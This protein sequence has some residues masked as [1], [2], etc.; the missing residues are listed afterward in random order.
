MAERGQS[1]LQSP[2]YTWSP[3]PLE[4]PV[5]AF[6]VG[7]SRTRTYPSLA[8]TQTPFATHD[9]GLASLIAGKTRDSE[10]SEIRLAGDLLFVCCFDQFLSPVSPRRALVQ[11]GIQAPAP[12]RASSPPSS[13]LSSASTID[14]GELSSPI[15][16]P[17]PAPHLSERALGYLRTPPRSNR[18]TEEDQYVTTSWG[19]P[20]PEA[21][22]HHL[23]R[24]S[25]SSGTSDESPL[26]QL[27]IDT[28]FLRPVPSISDT[29][30]TALPP[31]P[32][33]SGSAAVLAN[34]ARRPLGG[35]TEEWIRQHTTNDPSSEQRHWLSDGT[36]DSEHSSLSSS[37]S[38]NEAG[39]FEEADPRTP[40]PTLHSTPVPGPA[41]RQPRNRS[42]NETLRQEV[43]NHRAANT[44]GNMDPLD[45]EQ[46]ATQDAA[47]IHTIES[48]SDSTPRP[49]TP[50][51][52]EQAG[53]NGSAHDMGIESALPITPA[54]PTKQVMSQT[55]RLKKK[56]PWRGK[57][58]LVLIP[59]DE[60]RGQPGKAPKPLDAANTESMLRSWE[61]LGYNV[62]GFDL[63]AHQSK[64][65]PENNSRSRDEWPLLDDVAK[66]RSLRQYHVTL[67]DL[68]AWGKYV[69]ELAEAKLRALGVTFAEEEPVPQPS[70]SPVASNM[71]RQASNQFSPFPF[72]P[73]LPTSS[74]ASN[75]LQG[76]PF[77]APFF[78][79]GQTASQ[80]PALPAGASPVAFNAPI[81]GRFNAR[82]SISISPH[83]LPFH[84][85][86]Q[87]SPLGWSPQMLLQQQQLGRSASPSVLNP[88]SPGSP[89]SPDGMSPSMGIHQR[90]QSL[91]YPMLPHQF[92]H[93]QESARASP[94]LQE[95]REDDEE[96]TQT[97]PYDKSPSKTPEPAQF[98][99]HNA[100]NSLQ[101]EIDEAEYH[102]EEQFRSQLEHEDY[103]PHNEVRP[104]EADIP[105]KDFTADE[106]SHAR[107]P[108]VHFS[109]IG[110]ESDEEPRLHHPQ[111]HSR[112]HSLSQKPFFDNDEVR[113]STDEGSIKKSQSNITATA[114]AD[115]AYGVG[116]N[117]SNL[118]TPAQNQDFANQIHPRSLSMASNPWAESE[119]YPPSKLHSRHGSHNSKPSLSKLNA[120]AAEFRFNPKNNFT[121]GQ[122][123]FGGKNAQAPTFTPAS[124]QAPAFVPGLPQSATSSHFSVPS[125]T[126][127]IF[128][129]INP[130]APVFS[131]HKSDFSFST[132]GPK[133]NP[134]AKAFQP[135]GS[136]ASS[137]A[138]VGASGNEGVETRPK[139][140]FG[141]ID[142]NSSEYGKLDKT[143][144]AVPIMRPS[145]RDSPE[146]APNAA[147]TDVASIKEERP[148]GGVGRAK[149]QFRNEDNADGDD[150][151]QF[152]DPTPEPESPL[153]T[154][155][156]A[157]ILNNP[158]MEMS[159]EP[160]AVD[161]ITNTREDEDETVNIA[162]V[163][164][165]ST[166]VSESTDGKLPSESNDTKATTSPSATSPDPDKAN[167]RPIEF[168]NETD[169][170]DFNNAR[171]FG[172]EEP[173]F[174][175]LSKAHFSATAK[176]FVPGGFMFGTSKVVNT[177]FEPDF[178]TQPDLLAETLDESEEDRGGSPTPGPDFPT[179]TAIETQEVQK[180]QEVSP[181]PAPISARGLLSSRFASPPP[182][183][184]GLKASRFASSPSASPGSVKES[185]SRYAVSP[186]PVSEE[187]LAPLIVGPEGAFDAHSYEPL[188]VSPP[189]DAGIA[190]PND[191]TYGLTFEEIDAV[192]QHLND[193]DPT[194]GVKRTVESPKWHQPSLVRK[195]STKTIADSPPVHLQP[196]VPFRSEAP[197]PS[198]QQYR[199]L[200]QEP[201]HLKPSTELDDP[202]LDPPHSALSQSFDAQVQR[203][204]NRDDLPESE[205]DDAFSASEQGKL[206]QRVHYFDGHVHDLV[207]NLLDSRL[208]PLENT[209]GAIQQVLGK[210]SQRGSSMRRDRR[211]LSAE[212]RESDADDEDEELPMRRSM[213]PRRDRRLEQIR[214]AVID[215]MSQHQT[216]QFAPVE[217]HQ[218]KEEPT[219]IKA[220]EDMKLQITE[221]IPNF[222]SDDLRSIV[223]EAVKNHMPPIPAPVLE[224]DEEANRKLAEM[225]LKIEALEERLHTE[226]SRSD[227]ERL[228][229]RELEEKLRVG[230]TKVE[231]ETATRRAA[232]D[233]TAELRRQLEQAETKVEVEI[234]NRSI[235]DQRVH[236]LEDRLKAQEGKTEFE[237]SSRREAEDRLSEIQRLLRI[238]SEEEDR[239]R[240][241]LDLRDQKI[242]GIEQSSG[243]TSMRLA[244]LEAAQANAEQTQ[245]ELKN[246]LNIADSELRD[247]REEVQHWRSEIE[248]TR[249][250]AARQADDFV[251]SV[252]ENK[253]LHRLIDTLSV[254]LEENERIRDNWRAK[255]ASLQDDMAHAAR[256]ITEENSRRSK[257]EQALIARHEVLDA[258]LQAEARTRER[259]EVEV[260]RLENGERA[261][262]RAVNESKRLE[263]LLIELRNENHIIHQQALA[264]Q[265]E[266]QEA[267]DTATSDKQRAQLEVEEAKE[268][269]AAE[270][271]RAQLETQ[272]VKDSVA[273]E[274]HLAQLEIKEVKDAAAAEV[275]R[276]HQEVFEAQ[277]LAAIE[278]QQVRAS[279][280]LQLEA[281]RDQVNIVKADFEEEIAKLRAELDQVRLDADT[282]SA[283]HE[284][285]LEEAQNTKEAE[286]QA[287]KAARA[288]VLEESTYKHQNELED[289][290]ARYERQI[291]NAAED[292]QR[293]EQNLLERLS[294][295]AS[296]TEHLQDRVAHME[297]KV[298][299]AQEAA[300]AA[301]Q[302]A[303]HAS[304]SVAM[305]ELSVHSG[306]AGQTKQLAQAMQLPGKISPQA[307]RE[308]IMVL[309]EQ[310]QAREQ[311]IEELEEMVAGLDPDAATKISKRDD[312]ITWLRE[313]LAVRHGDLQDI[314]TALS[315]DRYDREGVRDAVIRLKANL[316]M[317]EQERER[318]MNGGSA[319]NLPNIAATISKAA[320]PRVAQAVGPLAA[321]WGNWRRSNQS[322]LNLS[323][324]MS[325]PATGRNATPSKSNSVSSQNGRLSGLMTPPASGIRNTP[326]AEPSQPQPTAFGNTGRRYTAEQFANRARGPS[327]T[328][329]QAESIPLASTPPPPEDRKE[330]RTPPMMQSNSYDDDARME[331]FDDASFFDD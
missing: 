59:R 75:G 241:V 185:D 44:L 298:Q 150:V 326:K 280:S 80:S 47:S 259:L 60:E 103:S 210:L 318:A 303:A 235:Y 162:D 73:P 226:E 254:Q 171:P 305:P 45:V 243:K 87:P 52:P 233:R 152:A 164:L 36:D 5:A 101:K 62:R 229:V 236:D 90:H 115:S 242:N 184:K 9:I 168:T 207:G 158:Q 131:P 173:V 111:P 208:D 17:I 196:Q 246:R 118:G 319:L 330:P 191:D 55:P 114:N 265:R 177:P 163:T 221:S 31:N 133:F 276:A 124:I 174:S 251:H 15:L 88:M 307:L 300:K 102:L 199:S 116:T 89:F 202:F 128:A 281:A 169:I 161:A 91:Q 148:D 293:T 204:N 54:K 18:G 327:A 48:N 313:L 240:A 201:I 304:K 271:Q 245:A 70:V 98:I 46:S 3:P 266:A 329:R 324:V 247:S 269:A 112:G 273:A 106:P 227:A 292:A 205:W 2:C 159:T 180:D 263:A 302:A 186:S 43:P 109:G 26:H 141:N 74:A 69:N 125:T 178:T 33:L 13:P 284:M 145:S 217:D 222:H 261:G 188:P 147:T 244:L 19:S 6:A 156:E 57:N 181:D 228:R 83:E 279:I 38:S 7:D 274:I 315:A 154:E 27:E 219:I 117:P 230:E 282:A 213:S 187:H 289:L 176:P 197:S 286:L 23:R 287:V 232:E 248:Q 211:S 189:S 39:W 66:E 309:Q 24:L 193:N 285:M 192:M 137:L 71:S 127:S 322:S 50:I 86:G 272:E 79:G 200:P 81:H 1:V 120:N 231:A 85:S 239:L 123:V 129:K 267:R 167:W 275:E 194:M 22:S 212:V 314:I 122:F 260:E 49:A 268:A 160:D 157:S 294:L 42:S 143:S 142:L 320:T 299:I 16:P 4:P 258:R 166:V 224:D 41:P 29:Q 209:L 252:N 94:R 214:I 328:A 175:E 110:I 225:Q 30:P 234:M 223:E 249:D 28:P 119:S 99:Q 21:D 278:A 290:Q 25:F 95:L 130:T 135:M 32:S 310:L 237:L 51:K 63:D 82:A 270:V 107:G 104:L 136:F 132:S 76:F 134:D 65:V 312:E 77:P 323:G 321:A 297:E 218:M 121:P 306:P 325:S 316:Q 96:E 126:S 72:S 262:M 155:P 183:P 264:A 40:R 301:A 58:I 93:R 198:P 64:G 215:A 78:P 34:R 190:L 308:S 105:V 113:D 288:A 144:N 138:S 146:S 12:R 238:S 56:V 331:E 20:Y 139:A 216:A 220:L 61:Q 68:N 151:P 256:E 295:S 10:T 283:L 257:K 35:I 165:A 296:K 37:I 203:L 92:L 14:D 317:E 170:H 311:R 291:S 179:T 253:H 250:S 195:I 11:D 277:D 100:S 108:S 149:K 84:F 53:M 172:D 97:N 140:I 153:N 8:A 67:P 255:F 182:P 206:E